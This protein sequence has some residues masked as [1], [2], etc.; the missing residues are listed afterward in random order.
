M[1][2]YKGDP[3]W[4]QSRYPSTCRACK[5]EIQRGSQIFYYPNGK[6]VYCESCGESAYRDFM[7]CAQDEGTYLSQY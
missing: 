7:A 5:T 3:Y 2:H 1:E 6:N 4:T